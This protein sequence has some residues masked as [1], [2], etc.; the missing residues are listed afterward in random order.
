MGGTE[1]SLACCGTRKG[2]D[3]GLLPPTVLPKLSGSPTWLATGKFWPSAQQD[4]ELRVRSAREI[5]KLQDFSKIVNLDEMRLLFNTLTGA[6][7]V[8]DQEEYQRFCTVIELAPEVQAEFW[9]I[10]DINGDG[11]V[12]HD[13]FFATVESLTGMRSWS[14]HCPDC[15]YSNNCH[16]CVTRP[17]DCPTGQC[18]D[19]RFCAECWTEHPCNQTVEK[20]TGVLQNFTGNL[21]AGRITGGST[22]PAYSRKSITGIRSFLSL[23]GS[24][25]GQRARAEALPRTIIK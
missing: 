21:I 18:N 9:E 15:M 5:K 3:H 1:S 24:V 4:D 16:F 8:M 17:F 11:V 23:P 20:Q 12:S 19:Q 25:F 22:K 2:P 6:D 7:N 13:E 14:R 10:L